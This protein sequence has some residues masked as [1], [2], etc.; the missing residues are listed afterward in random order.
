MRKPVTQHNILQN[1]PSTQSDP[2]KPTVYE[3]KE[4]RLCHTP[5]SPRRA[6][7]LTRT[8]LAGGFCEPNSPHEQSWY[9]AAKCSLATWLSRGHLPS[10]VWRQKLYLSEEGTAGFTAP[11][12]PRELEV[13]EPE[14][15]R[16]MCALAQCMKK[17]TLEYGGEVSTQI[18]TS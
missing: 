18:C 1:E 11:E 4:T 10:S 17:L 13:E 8:A 15:F 6:A 5:H 9:G 7:E 14:S 12:G 16:L 3:P 2:A